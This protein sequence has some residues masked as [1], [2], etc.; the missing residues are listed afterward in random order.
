M[1]LI[2]VSL[3]EGDA[4]IVYTTDAAAADPSRVSQ[5][6][7]PDVLNVVAT[8]PIA[9]VNNSLNLDLARVYIAYVLSTDGQNILAKYGF[10]P[11][12]K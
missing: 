1:V 9:P 10:I 8:Y 2:K 11:V 5:I 3:G 4:G 12:K 6:I 7:I